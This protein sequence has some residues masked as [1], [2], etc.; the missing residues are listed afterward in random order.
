MA[1]GAVGTGLSALNGGLGNLLGGLTGWNSGAG[2]NAPVNRYE[3][4]LL[5]SIAARDAKIEQLEAEKYTGRQAAGPDES[6]LR[7][8]PPR[9]AS[10]WMR[11]TTRC[12]KRTKRR[13]CLRRRRRRR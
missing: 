4:N 11:W 5:N 1:L 13:R 12:A 3:V 9:G 2:D 8:F 10:G 7:R 6:G